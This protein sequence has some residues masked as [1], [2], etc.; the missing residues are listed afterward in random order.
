MSLHSET[1]EVYTD[2]TLKHDSSHFS[3]VEQAVAQH[4]HNAQAVRLTQLLHQHQHKHNIWWT[5]KPCCSFTLEVSHNYKLCS[6][7]LL[8]GQ[9]LTA[10]QRPSL[11]VHILY[12]PACMQQQPSNMKYFEAHPWPL[13]VP[14]GW[15]S[16]RFLSTGWHR[17]NKGKLSHAESRGWCNYWKDQ[18]GRG[19]WCL[20]LC[21]W[22]HHCHHAFQIDEAITQTSKTKEKSTVKEVLLS[23]ILI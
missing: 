8:K 19:L 7:E 9:L 10:K 23:E 14:L 20:L 3:R 22:W 15:L 1:A 4:N 2:E 18:C 13:P 6:N 5:R 12:K 17:R 16:A 11:V 21:D